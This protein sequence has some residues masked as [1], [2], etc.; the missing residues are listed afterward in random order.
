MIAF[1]CPRCGAG[2]VYQPEESGI[3]CRFCGAQYTV[4]ACPYCH[5]STLF[6]A[7]AP[8]SYVFCRACG[9][10]AK[11]RKWRPSTFAQIAVQV[12]QWA[13]KLYGTNAAQRE[14]DPQR[15]RVNGSILSLTGVSGIATGGCTVVFDP[16]YV[17]VLLGTEPNVFG[18]PY[19]DVN[20]LQ[21]AGRGAFTTASGG[22]W[23]GGAFIPADLEIA[24][25]AKALFTS[26]ALT[27]VLNKLTT[28]K[29]HHIET[30]IHLSWTT[31]SLTG[32]SNLSGQC[33]V[34]VSACR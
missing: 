15:R 19:K 2:A 24:G 23:V 34:R 11:F 18:I 7:S 8:S 29:Q 31:G 33:L 17:V 25:T 21:I 5:A 14:A 20:A 1:G 3:Q 12:P 22:G 26:Y 16:T 9:S 28:I 10:S 13:S 6:A 27:T 4:A 30:I 32:S